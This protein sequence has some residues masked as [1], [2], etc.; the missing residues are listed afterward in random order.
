[1]KPSIQCKIYVAG[2]LASLPC[3]LMPLLP[4]LKLIMAIPTS[5]A[6]YRDEKRLASISS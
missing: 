5:P 6:N 2:P 3:E 1:M 4:S